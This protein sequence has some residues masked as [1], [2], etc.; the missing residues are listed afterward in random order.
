MDCLLRNAGQNPVVTPTG[1]RQSGKTPLVG[2]A[3]PSHRRLSLEAIDQ[4]DFAREEPRGFLARLD[5]PVILDEIQHVPDLPPFIQA[6][7]D[8]GPAPGRFV[9]TVSQNFLLMTK[10]G[11]DHRGGRRALS[12]GDQIRPDGGRRHACRPSLVVRAQRPAA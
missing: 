10:S 8:Q 11:S 5:S 2:S 6:P 7:V 12:G 9:W 3:F 4:R 1:P